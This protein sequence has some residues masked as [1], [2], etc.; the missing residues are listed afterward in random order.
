MI[1]CIA[2]DDE[3]LALDLIAN[4]CAQIDYLDLKKTFTRPSAAS[5]Y[6]SKFPVDLLF[7]DIQMPDISGIDFYRSLKYEKPVI[8]TTAYSSYAVEGF[9]LNAVDYL[10][11]PIR[12][13][14][15]EQAVVKTKEYL[16]YINN[17]ISA[18]DKFLF[19]RSDYKLM[20]IGFSEILF[21]Q[22][23]DNY[24]RIFTDQNKTVMSRV[25]LKEIIAKL[26]GEMFARIH[27]SYI[28]NL[29]KGISYH[30]KKIQIGNKELPVGLSFEKDVREIFKI[31]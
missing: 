5:E 3:P 4:Y 27:R 7:L 20:K 6:L 26:P 28:I 29:K 30:N 17:K 9:N 22:G 16:E 12:F 25:S 19:V 21:I 14:R 10:L 24:I 11:K 13:G 31:Q 1:R 23:L 18:E 2:I 15:F 8:F